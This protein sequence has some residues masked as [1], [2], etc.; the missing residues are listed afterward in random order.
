MKAYAARGAALSRL[1]FPTTKPKKAGKRMYAKFEHGKI[2]VRKKGKPRV[3]VT[4][5][6]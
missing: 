6:S 3:R 1:G 4:F 5:T 2:S